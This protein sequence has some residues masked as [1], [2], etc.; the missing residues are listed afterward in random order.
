MAELTFIDKLG[1]TERL[2]AHEGDTVTKVLRAN[3]IPV[4][5]VITTRDGQIVSE[6]T[7]VLSGSAAIV[8]TQSRHYDLAVT[9]NPPHKVYATDN[10]V[11]TKSVLFD[12]R[13]EIEI[14][15]EQFDAA[16]MI[17]YV[18]QTFVE[19]VTN[20]GILAEGDEIFI[21]LSGGRDSVAFLTLLER[22]RDRLPKFDM[23]AVT[24]TGLPD[25]EEPGTY[26]A[27]LDSCRNLGISHVLVAG[28][29]IK[30]TFA[31]RDTFTDAMTDVI[32]GEAH[33]MVMVITHQV[34][35]RMIEVVATRHGARTIAL[36]L[37]SDDLM[38]SLVTW[39]TSGFTMGGIPAREVGDFRYV[40]PIF[41]L[42]K[43]EL[44]IYLELVDPSL[45][46]Q[47]TPG[48]FTTG[49]GERSLA[50]AVTDNLYELWP[51]IDYYVFEA[52]AQIQAGML[53]DGQR[54]HIDCGVCGSSF[55]PQVGFRSGTLCDICDLFARRELSRVR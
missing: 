42:T 47:G 28:D 2:V 32:D 9:R 30:D 40:F 38:A 36:G 41:Q 29:E 16:G 48:R 6:D 25:W 46:R 3:G 52:Y 1:R 35:R 20:A 44:T 54:K 13:G 21:G 17:E 14:R 31:L 34:M 27:A 18:E 50:Y 33:S 26:Q 24:V 12:T 22:T 10:A 19:S 43:K 51:G 7:T 4:N 37:N 8:C 5:C 15:S 49:P 53:Q 23:T 55:V 45:N 11:Y 39:F